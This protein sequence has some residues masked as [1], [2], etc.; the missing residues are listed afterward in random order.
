MT[1]DPH[2]GRANLGLRMI[3]GFETTSVD[4]PNYGKYFFQEWNKNKLQH[5]VARRQL[6]HL[7]QPGALRRRMR[8]ESGRG[9]RV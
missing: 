3:F 2:M 8:R 7:A 6:A 9:G 4:N 1:P 5:R